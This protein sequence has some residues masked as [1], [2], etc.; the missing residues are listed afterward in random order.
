ME[1]A[2]FE[3]Q[4]IAAA[5][6]RFCYGCFE[7][8]ENPN[9]VA[10]QT[11][12][13]ASKVASSEIS[14]GDKVQLRLP[15]PHGLLKDGAIGEVVEDDGS[16]CLPLKVRLED[17]HDY[18][19]RSD[20]EV[21]LPELPD[22]SDRAT[23][24]GTLRYMA[25]KKVAGVPF[26]SSGLSMSP[27]GFGCH[28]LTDVDKNKAALGLAIQL[29]CNVVDLAPN[30]TDGEAETVAGVV[31]ENLIK[32]KLV[33]R[34]QL[35][36]MSKV[37]N[38]LGQQLKHSEGVPNMARINDNLCHCISP[39][40]IDQEIT[41]ILE[42]LKLKCIDCLLLH[43]PEYELKSGID[44]TEV[45]SRLKEA[46]KH[47]ELEVSRGRIASYGVSGAFY[48]LR[49]TDP[50]HLDLESVMAQLP[51]SHHFR[52]LQFPLNYAEA[53]TMTVSHT[54]RTPDGVAIDRERGLDA[55]TLFEAARAHGLAVFTN[56]PLDGIYKESHGVLRFSSL[57]AD[58]RSFS[59]L[60]L[61]NCDAMEEKLTNLCKLDQPPYHAGAGAAGQ[62][63]AKTVKTLCSLSDVDCVLLGMRQPEYVVGTLALAFG[64]PPLPPETARNAVRALH[65]TVTMWY[66]TAINEA[67]HGTAKDWRLPMPQ[68]Q[69]THDT[70][71]DIT[72]TNKSLGA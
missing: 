30:Y 65:S 22:D 64:T 52:A 43:C 8:G 48:P 60:Q 2:A 28:R 66:A 15:K 56:R 58:V 39:A 18:Y 47:L 34:D 44:M 61:D 41:R 37:G 69:D 5:A 29:G 33:R 51:A 36:I 12:V 54:P 70:L 53:Q 71:M 38:V 20:L 32:E 25:S 40:W 23:P 31:I 16:D 13:L 27:V 42:R 63:A 49:P 68:K 6:E 21:V 1:N 3:D 26:G 59:E 4:P 14:V 35:I 57:D 10:T 46:F 7:S 24:E 62:L 45:Y 9:P 17:A 50:E 67:D 11:P 19:N 72:E 55:P